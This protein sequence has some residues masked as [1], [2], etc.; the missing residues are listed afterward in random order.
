MFNQT[1]LKIE[2]RARKKTY[3]IHKYRSFVIAVGVFLG[4]I[5]FI[6]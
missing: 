4:A 6:I 5:L 2:E 1:I 3:P